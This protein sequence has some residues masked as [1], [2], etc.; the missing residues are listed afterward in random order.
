MEQA[1][2]DIL[3]QAIDGSQWV[4]LA[5]AILTVIVWLIRQFAGHWIKQ[6]WLPVVN[7]G[8]GLLMSIAA[9]LMAD[10]AWW[11][12]IFF[13]LLVGGAAGGFWSL[14]GK[15]ILPTKKSTGNEG[16]DDDLQK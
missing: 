10:V 5:G 13:G 2:I 16:A 8:L 12:A 1:T 15:K 9:S 6:E 14:L 11:K 3:I 7:S 4:V